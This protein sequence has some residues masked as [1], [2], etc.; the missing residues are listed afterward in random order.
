MTADSDPNYKDLYGATLVQTEEISTIYFHSKI[1]KTFTST[2]FST[3]F[4]NVK[5]LSCHNILFSFLEQGLY[6]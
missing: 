3:V 1:Y 6:S 5:Q 2:C 4:F